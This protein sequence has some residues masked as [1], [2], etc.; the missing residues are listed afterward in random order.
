MHQKIFLILLLIGSFFSPALLGY[1]NLGEPWASGLDLSI[2]PANT[3]NTSLDLVVAEHNLEISGNLTYGLGYNSEITG[4]LPL[5]LSEGK[6]GIGDI[7]FGIKYTANRKTS[8]SANF[9]GE[10]ALSLPTGDYKNSLGSGGLGILL[11]W[12]VAQ[13][14][15]VGTAHFGFGFQSN[16]EN[17]ERLKFGDIFFWRLGLTRNLATRMEKMFLKDVAGTAE[18]KGWNHFSSYLAGQEIAGS[19]YNELYLSLGIAGKAN[20]YPVKL[21][22]N[23][24]LNSEVSSKLGLFAAVWF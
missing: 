7:I 9:A 2:S 8:S 11:D 3:Y 4:K 17:P 22:L 10:L 24:G 19:A 13:K 1:V 20:N 23:I 14:F 15:P 16:S 6:F 5:L 18:L 21:A 12:L